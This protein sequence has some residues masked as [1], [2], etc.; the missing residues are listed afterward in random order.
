MSRPRRVLALP[1]ASVWHWRAP[2]LQGLIPWRGQRSLYPRPLPLL[3]LPP[4]PSAP[5]SSRRYQSPAVES[6]RPSGPRWRRGALR[7]G[8]PA[9]CRS[10]H[11]LPPAPPVRSAATAPVPRVNPPA[12]GSL[13][14]VAGPG[15]AGRSCCSGQRPPPPPAA[16]SLARHAGPH[17]IRK[18]RSGYR[19][20]PVSGPA[21]SAS[22]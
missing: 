10:A 20:Y 13:P 1:S 21:A 9:R 11:C 22:W 8:Q 12:G 19:Q 15:A 16:L 17:S 2:A 18:R 6:A 4:P 7:S 5:Q 14:A 3:P